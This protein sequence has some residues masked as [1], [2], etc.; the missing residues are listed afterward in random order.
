MTSSDRADGSPS[1][2]PGPG[3]RR[4]R[5]HVTSYEI[6]RVCV[7]PACKTTLSRYNADDLCWRHA[8]TRAGLLR[9][10]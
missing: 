6:G 5:A 8:E 9:R 10:P 7:D 1:A 4:N 2:K 3:S